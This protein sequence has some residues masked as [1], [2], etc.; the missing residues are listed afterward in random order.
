MIIKTIFYALF[1]YLAVVCLIAIIFTVGICGSYLIVKLAAYAIDTF[2]D[3]ID[4]I[5]P[6]L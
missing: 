6:I 5:D 4:A 2:M 3:F 1:S